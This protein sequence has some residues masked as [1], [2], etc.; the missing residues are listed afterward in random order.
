[1][2]R[3]SVPKKNVKAL[4]NGYVTTKVM[5]WKYTIDN[6]IN[7]YQRVCLIEVYELLSKT[8]LDNSKILPTY[9]NW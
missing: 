8:A 6:F 7:F 2:K 3:K 1:M 4:V 9:T 5:L